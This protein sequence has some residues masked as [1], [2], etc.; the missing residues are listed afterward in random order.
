MTE[1]ELETSLEE[2]YLVARPLGG[3]RGWFLTCTTRYLQCTTSN[4]Y[5]IMFEALESLRFI[6]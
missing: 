2:S 6:G 5:K 3:V 4:K 1:E